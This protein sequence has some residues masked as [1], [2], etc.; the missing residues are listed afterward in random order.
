TVYDRAPSLHGEAELAPGFINGDGDRVGEVQ[1]AAVGAHRQAQAALVRQ[2]IANLGRQ[3]AAF[4]AEQE[5]VAAL[6][7]DLMERLRALGGEAEQTGMAEAGQADFQIRSEER[8]VG[9]E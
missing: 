5:G 1:A 6:E 4:G 7:D 3:A 8:R 2:R 9:K